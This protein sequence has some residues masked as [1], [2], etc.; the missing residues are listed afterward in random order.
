MATLQDYFIDVSS[1]VAAWLGQTSWF[2]QTFIASNSYRI[3]SVKLA[4][5]KEAGASPGTITVS[6]RATSAGVPSGG[7]LATGTTDGDT[8]TT[9][10]EWREITFGSSISLTS[11]VKY[12]IVARVSGETAYWVANLEGHS[13]ANGAQCSSADSGSNWS[14]NDTY[15]LGFETWGTVQV[16][17]EAAGSISGTGS[18]TA[19][20]RGTWGIEGSSFGVGSVTGN[21]GTNWE[22]EGSSFGV[23]SVAG[24]AK[25]NRIY[26]AEGAI[27]G[28]G[29]ITGKLVAD[30]RVGGIIAGAGVATGLFFIESYVW[31]KNRPASYDKTKVYDEATQTWITSDSRGG[32]RFRNQLIVMAKQDDGNA[33]I[34]FSGA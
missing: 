34:Y 28:S 1:S 10:V 27:A 31:M 19:D 18:T 12:A 22:I 23:G 9:D 16:N 13:Y 26:E 29:E 8:L 30:W 17:H 6:I 21:A 11:G 5:K 2:A 4:L 7:D 25:V 14:E 32:S 24:T 20:A 3:S 15:D 33:K